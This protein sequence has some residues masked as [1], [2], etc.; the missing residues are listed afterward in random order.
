MLLIEEQG[1]RIKVNKDPGIYSFE[2]LAATGKSY[3]CRTCKR[4]RKSGGRVAGYDYEDYKRGLPLP[5]D[6]G[7]VVVD[8]YEKYQVL[9]DELLELAKACIVLVDIKTDPFPDVCAVEFTA[10]GSFLVY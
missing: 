2:P 3:L 9:D 1:T 5:K 6:V 4:L 7:L 10:D 8:R